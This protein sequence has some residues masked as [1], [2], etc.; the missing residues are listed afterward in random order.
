MTE[1]KILGKVFPEPQ[2]EHDPSRSY[3]KLQFVTVK[4]LEETSCYIAKEDIS[5]G[6]AITDPY[7]QHLFTTKNGAKGDTGANGKS[8]YQYATEGG[9][10][11]TEQEFTNDILNAVNTVTLDDVKALG[12]VKATVVQELPANPDANTIYFVQ[13]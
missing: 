3:E 8:A 6:T 4:S 1:N 7:W 2:G 13:A 5:T 11:G 9:Y 10:K 12:Y